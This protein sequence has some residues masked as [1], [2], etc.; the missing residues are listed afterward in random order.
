M[1][2]FANLLSFAEATHIFNLFLLDGET[3]I[4]DLILNIYRNM[5]GNILKLKDEFEVQAY[6]SKAIYDEALEKGLFYPY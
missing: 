4:V 6:M 5:Q 2:L 3:F 1:T